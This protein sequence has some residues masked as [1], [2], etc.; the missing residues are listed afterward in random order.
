MMDRIQNIRA[1]EEIIFD[2]LNDY[3]KDVNTYPSDAVLQINTQSYDISIESPVVDNDIDNIS[4]SELI[5]AEDDEID[6]DAVNEL[7]NKYF[8]VR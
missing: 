6:C 7:A 8:F 5:S 2:L 3:T 1:F 4:L